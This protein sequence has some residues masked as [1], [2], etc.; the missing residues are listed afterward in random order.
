METENH[1]IRIRRASTFNKRKRKSVN[2]LQRAVYHFGDLAAITFQTSINEEAS[3]ELDTTRIV[4]ISI[5]F[6]FEGQVHIDITVQIGQY[7]NM[8]WLKRV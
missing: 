6:N 4:Y 5:I 7:G 1:L 2:S 8:A 3:F